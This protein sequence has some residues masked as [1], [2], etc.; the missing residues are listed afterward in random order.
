[1][2]FETFRILIAL[3]LNL[4]LYISSY[5]VVAAY[6][7]SEID[8]EIYMTQPENYQVG[9]NVLRLKKGLYGLR[10][11]AKLWNDE[12]KEKLLEFG[13]VQS[14]ND[15]GLFI[16]VMDNSFLLDIGL[17]GWHISVF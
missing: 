13:C 11:S 17:R 16:Y 7:Y 12:L 15:P 4:G 3:A 14:I 9:D 6:L 1:M 8:Q 2:K 5:D 10:Q